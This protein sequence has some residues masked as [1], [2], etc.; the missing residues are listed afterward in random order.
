MHGAAGVGKS[1]LLDYL[2]GRAFHCRLIRA[3]G[4]Q[5]EMELAF[6]AL[7]QLCGPMVDHLEEL[8]GPQREA[9][10]TAFGMIAG[11]P[12]DR[13]L[14]GMAFLSMLSE[15][16]DERP[17]VCLIDDEQWLD[18]ASAQVLAFVARRLVA[19]SVGLVFAARVPGRDLAGLPRLQ[20]GGLPDAEA[21]AL[22]DTVL[23][24]PL[25]AQV[26]DQIVAET[27]GNPLALVELPRGL[28]AQELAGGFGL[29]SAARLSGTVEESF[30]RR[31][32]AMPGPTRELL[33]VV[34]S[35]PTGDPA[36]I[37]SAAAQLGVGAD[38]A[39]PA[40]D[41]GLV[42]LGTRLWFRHPLARSAAYHSG[43]LL[44]RQRVHR[45]L[46]GVTDSTLDP[47]R[48]AWHLA[49]ATAKPDE[50]IAIE[51]LRSAD[52]ARA[53]G[54]VAAAAAFLERATVLTLDPGKRA[55]R[56]LDAAAAKVEAGAFDAALD[57]I[58]RAEAGPL[59]DLQRARVDL[60]RA[61]LAFVTNRGSDA[62]PLLLKAAKQL[63]PVDVALSRA[64]YLEAMSAAMF[65]GRLAAGCGVADVA[66]AAAASPRPPT[67]LLS[68]LLL[69]GYVAR[70]ADRYAVAVQTLRRAVSAAV[71]SSGEALRFLWLA[72]IAALDLWDDK[73]WD[74]L[75]ERHVEVA[76]TTGVLTELSLAL[77]TRAV[78]H[79]FAGELRAA[80][81]LVQEVQVVT[82]ATGAGLAPYGALLQAA[83]RGDQAEVSALV[84]STTKDVMRRGEGIGL[85]V[86]EHAE[87]LLNNGIG[88]YSVAM[89]AAQHAVE[90]QMDLGTSGWC[91]VE[92]VEAAARCGRTDTATDT[93]AR[94]TELTNA[95]G[96]DW[97]LGVQVRSRALLSDGADAERLY[98][99]AIARLARTRIRA[100]LAR[101]HLLYGEWLRRERRRTDARAQ[102]RM[103]HAML[104]A[105]GMEA[106][107]ER[108]R[109]ELQATGETARK[110]TTASAEGGQLTAQEAQIA[111][112]AR[113]GLSNP[114][115]GARLFISARTVQYHL[116]KVFT[117]LDISSRSQLARVL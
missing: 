49:N 108:A 115:I 52:R 82:E 104:D 44:Q 101:A 59:N 57:L 91:L 67:P 43:S 66:R 85:S 80:E 77:S 90:H 71:G 40:V 78:M 24:G 54:G 31:I 1:A 68:D 42:E 62:P 94:L 4:V 17:L 47:D 79:L 110:R 75:S 36:L 92:L 8:P 107:A 96:T 100:E 86:G 7:H 33:L 15:A 22:L 112:L 29:P 20:V 38:A 114:E 21:R 2:A 50:D 26:R 64:T 117:K 103:A 45:A 51:L 63:E 12:P 88:N 109:R 3:A 11:P 97:A 23:T 116:R 32:S 6:A 35:E 27:H 30:R 46:A 72:G 106:F 83:F 13:F 89:A 55:Q 69:D 93:L 37:W 53:R 41:A 61:Q 76:R 74:V 84:E 39:A 81:A 98:R 102:L 5:S 34:A 16:A 9:L 65:S 70:F 56:A 48:C 95:A 73:S 19:E 10:Q 87:A 14:V 25:D 113:D 28:S 105:M 60:V 58:A 111:R 99:E 18:R